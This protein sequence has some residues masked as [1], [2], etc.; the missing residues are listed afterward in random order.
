[1]RVVLS[2]SVLAMGCGP[3]EKETYPD[4]V[5]TADVGL[6]DATTE[7]V[8][9]LDAAN[10]YRALMGLEPGVLGLEINTA[11]Q[12]HAEYMERNGR[13]SHQEQAGRS[14]FTGEWV[15]DRIDAAGRP[16]GAGEMVS[17]VVASGYTP[18]GAVDGWMQTVYHRMPFT[19][20]AWIE[21]GFGQEGEYSSMS[22][23]TGF[24]AGI[25]TG[26]IYPADGQVEVNPSFQSDW[27]SPDPA[28]DHG[29]VGTPITV[30]VTD[31]QTST[32]DNDPFNT[33]LVSGT[34]VD[35]AGTEVEI[36]VA[37]PSTDPSLYQMVMLLPVEPL[38]ATT[39]YTAT[40]VVSWMGSEEIFESTFT[41]A[42]SVAE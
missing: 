35:S 36:M 31:E 18:A 11:T 29:E 22:F 21:I 9:G 39:T 37:D 4:L 14:G 25:R 17:E 3:S 38:Q 41:T 20:P 6:D 23:L 19:L 13:I 1:M 34:L 42:D 15:W 30:T 32:S 7:Q 12:W 16:L 2:L 5:C 26:V 33:R 10:C 28:P 8:L 40:V 24:P 27:E